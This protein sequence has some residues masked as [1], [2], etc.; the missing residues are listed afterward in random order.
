MCNFT[1]AIKGAETFQKHLANASG[2]FALGGRNTKSRIK[3]PSSRIQR[4]NNTQ[5]P[6]SGWDRSWF[7]DAPPSARA[8]PKEHAHLNIALCSSSFPK[9]KEDST[10]MKT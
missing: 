3:T 10:A 5:N 9:F 2:S 6:N 8:S 1:C 4:S 7:W